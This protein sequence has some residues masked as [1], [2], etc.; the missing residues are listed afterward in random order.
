MSF[1][2][3]PAAPSGITVLGELLFAVLGQ[4]EGPTPVLISPRRALSTLDSRAIL[5]RLAGVTWVN[6][7]LAVSMPHLPWV[8]GTATP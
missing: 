2:S 8:A 1:L 5:P 4:L 3:G 6:V 7:R